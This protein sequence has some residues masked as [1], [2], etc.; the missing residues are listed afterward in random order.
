[1]PMSTMT[2]A[3]AHTTVPLREQILGVLFQYRA[4]TTQQLH[5][6]LLPHAHGEYLR[7][8]LR[9]LRDQDLV[10]ALV[11]ARH[12]SV[13][14]LTPEGFGHV[15]QWP[16][17]H[18]RRPYRAGAGPYGLRSQHTLT[19]TRTAAAFLRDARLRG[20][21]FAPLDWMPEVAHPVR[22]GTAGGERLL[23]ADALLHYATGG[24]SRMLLRAF[25]EVDRA[26]MS[27]E[28]VASKLITYARF[29]ASAPSVPGRRAA[30]AGAGQ[31]A[32][33]VWQQYYPRFPR[34]LFVLTGAGPQA[35]GNRIT[36][37]QAM[38]RQNPLVEAFA[39]QVPLGAAVL[40]DLEEHGPRAA[41]WT[42]LCRRT[43]RCS[44][45]AL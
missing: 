36:D 24:E 12:S 39:A 10:D 37:L 34:V 45:T 44:W 27:S 33:P 11:Q 14:A 28:R 7:R 41:V 16:Q 1:M 23:V 18:G 19:V 4:A 25:V 13:W 2:T 15:A 5:S 40:E 22:D 9:Q 8:C 20:D 3:P 17:F 43:E 38:T 31:P 21:G 29:H 6:M 35:L 30:T 42:P 32:L 26:T